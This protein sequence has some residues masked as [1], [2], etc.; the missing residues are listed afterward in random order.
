MSEGRKRRSDGTVMM[1]AAGDVVEGEGVLD[2]Q[3]V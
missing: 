3:L 1:V 2:V